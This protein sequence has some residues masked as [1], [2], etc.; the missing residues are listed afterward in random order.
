MGESDID[1][2][3]LS[4]TELADHIEQTHHAYLHSELPRLDEM[5]AKVVSDHGERNPS[6]HRIREIFLALATEMSSH[7]MKEERI[8]FPM[9]RELDASEMT[10]SFHCGTLANPIRQMESEH[11]QAGS[12]L[13]DLHELADGYTPPD[14]ACDNYRALLDALARFEHDLQLHIHKESDVLFPRALEMES[15]KG[16]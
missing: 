4:L 16:S 1:V 13:E 15:K 9:V 11:T 6:L 10:P 2:T 3:T 12:A 14:W 8:L 5:M 7:M